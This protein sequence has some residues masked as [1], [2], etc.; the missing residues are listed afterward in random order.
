M[1][2]QND[3]QMKKYYTHDK[4]SQNGPYSIDE[5]KEQGITTKTMIWYEGLDE[6]TEA[7]QIPELKEFATSVPP[8]FSKNNLF[9]QSKESAKK[10]LERDF[11]E[12]IESAIPNNKGKKLYK[13]LLLILSILGLIFIGY[14]IYPSKEKKE[15]NNPTEFLFLENARLDEQNSYSGYYNDRDFS[16]I[17]KGNII[18]KAELTTY[19]DVKIQLEYFSQTETSLGKDVITIMQEF[20]P[21][22][23]I[24]KKPHGLF[25]YAEL[26]FIKK[27]E[28]KPPQNADIQKTKIEIIDA[29]VMSQ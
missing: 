16:I 1:N 15:K 14:I 13:L 3:K 18:N 26:H 7:A 20:S 2:Q 17:L 25:G 24:N 29:E 23:E 11:I 6:W 19:K 8:K 10:V 21:E 5:L 12:E 27:I 9:N 22:A 28:T 4:D